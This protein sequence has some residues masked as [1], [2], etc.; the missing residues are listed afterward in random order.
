MMAPLT[1]SG[2]W[3]V[4]RVGGVAGEAGDSYCRFKEKVEPVPDL[5]R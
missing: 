2:T 3:K 4:G 1:K 5:N